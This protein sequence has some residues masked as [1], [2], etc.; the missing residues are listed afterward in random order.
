VAWTQAKYDGGELSREE[1]FGISYLLGNR[2]IERF[3]NFKADLQLS[4]VRFEISD[5]G[6]ELQESFN[7]E[8]VRF[9]DSPAGEEKHLYPSPGPLKRATL[10]RR[11]RDC[12]KNFSNWDTC[13]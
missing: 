5:F 6:F 3:A 1:F 9:H 7:F 4:G 2:E 12:S 13:S 11:G 10:S 8:I